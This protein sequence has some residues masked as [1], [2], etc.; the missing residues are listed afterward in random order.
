MGSWIIG[1]MA[2]IVLL[3]ITIVEYNFHKDDDDEKYDDYDK[4]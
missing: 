1:I 4:S 2:L 3:G